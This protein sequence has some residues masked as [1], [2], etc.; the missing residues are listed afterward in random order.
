LL[1]I[2]EAALVDLEKLAVN[3]FPTTSTTFGFCKEANIPHI[4]LLS[5]TA[6][7]KV[8]IGKRFYTL[9]K[10]VE[11]PKNLE[12]LSMAGYF[13]HW[14]QIPTKDEVW[15]EN[16]KT[17]HTPREI[18]QEFDCVFY[19]TENALF[20]DEQIVKIQALSNTIQPKPTNFEYVC[21]TGHIGRGTFYRPLQK[22]GNYILGIDMSKGK[23]L[24]Y[25]SI[26]VFDFENLDQIF[27]FKDN[28]I[29]HDDF[30]KFLHYLV[31]VLLF[32]NAT[33]IVISIESNATGTA[34]ISDLIALNP[35]YKRL[36]YRDTISQ[37]IAKK[38]R[39]VL[40]EY[41][42]CDYGVNV[43][44][45][46]RDLL[47]NYL[48]NYIDKNLDRIASKELLNEI[49]SLQIDKDGKVIGTPH[50]DLVLALGHVLLIRYRSRL[51]EVLS[52]YNACND[53]RAD[54]TYS[55]LFTFDKSHEMRN[56]MTKSMKQQVSEP[57]AFG[58]TDI[59][60]IDANR[61]TN[62]SLNTINFINQSTNNIIDSP[63]NN[64]ILQGVQEALKLS[65]MRNTILNDKYQ[66]EQLADEDNDPA[67]CW[68]SSVF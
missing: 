66:Q 65:S 11:P 53:I 44:S 9:W 7:G 54:S 49:E 4:I 64:N 45:N 10:E 62:V 37:D 18:H 48:F 67:D 58:N 14:T 34:V 29:G 21:P 13:L 24:D 63:S 38:N 61:Q 26:Q 5:S 51:K 28:R 20:S 56:N 22:H 8:G 27:E 47:I 55:K 33:N 30:V 3:I 41:L 35:L 15:Y 12:N 43:S 59:F 50:D 16:L 42:K 60:G 6:N 36:I 17:M 19:G 2:D 68:I 1:W 39:G 52:I 32:S 46:T 25:T 23:G 31:Y 40:I 57:I